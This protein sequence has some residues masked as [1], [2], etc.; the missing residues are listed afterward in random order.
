MGWAVWI[1]GEVLLL[2]HGYGILMAWAWL[3]FY[4]L[5]LAIGYLLRWKHGRWKTH[6][7]LAGI[8]RPSL[9]PPVHDPEP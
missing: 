4:V 5:L 6:D 8:A 7:L 2:Y 9:S 1:P 3:A